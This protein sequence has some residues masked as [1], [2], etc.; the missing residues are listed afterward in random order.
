MPLSARAPG[1]LAAILITATALAGC[2]G[3]TVERVVDG[4]VIEGRFVSA[5]AYALYGR[6]AYE[7]AQRGQRSD[8]GGRRALAALEAAAS[9]DTESAHLWMEI[10]ALRCRPPGADYEGAHAALERARALEPEEATIRRALAICHAAEAAE[11][12]ASG[13]GERAR[14]QGDRAREEALQAVQLDPDDVDAASLYASLLADAGRAPEGLRLLR[15]LTI[16]RPGSIEAW[17]ALTLFAQATHN[18]VIAERAARRAR[19]LAPRLAAAIE[20][21]LPPL[22]PLAELDDALRRGDL[23]AAHRRA[24][25]AHLPLAE[26]AVRAA[27]LG[28]AATA[29]A[30]AALVLAA[31]PADVTARIALAVA[32]DLAGDAGALAEALGSIPPSPAALTGPS[33]LA[34]LLFAE[35][36]GRRVDSG[37][38]RA[39]LSALPALGAAPP[40]GDALLAEV[41]ARVRARFASPPV[42]R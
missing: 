39:W 10:G 28:R 29:R 1:A 30:D 23:D 7:E 27:A 11:A 34:A 13:D 20:A 3:P 31:D 22:A 19:E 12:R 36:L 21:E 32:A 42:A 8:A 35:L 14:I 4:R 24:K 33:P 15:A 9:E 40:P 2:A 5:Y 41:S 16:R 25:R 38:A 17:R 37:A 26:V 18:E 6:A